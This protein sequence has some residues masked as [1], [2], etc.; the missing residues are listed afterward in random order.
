MSRTFELG[1]CVRPGW[2]GSLPLMDHCLVPDSAMTHGRREAGGGQ[3]G[4]RRG[5]RDEDCLAFA[6]ARDPLKLISSA[7][8]FSSAR[9][10]RRKHFT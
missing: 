3:A 7:G 4:G 6:D 2:S 8:L 5:A 10:H 9:K 1:S